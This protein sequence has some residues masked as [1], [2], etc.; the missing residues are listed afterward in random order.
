MTKKVLKVV[1]GV[2]GALVLVIVVYVI[3]VMASYYRL[4]DSISLETTAPEEGQVASAIEW[5]ADGQES[6][7]EFTIVS[8]NLGFGAYGPDFDFFM[9]GGS[10]SVAP[11]AQYVTDNV[12]GSADA[13]K[14]FDPDIVLFQEVD[15]DGTRSQGVDEYALL[16]NDFP[17]LCSVFVQNY[18]SPYLAWPLYAP[19]GKNKAGMATFSRYQIESTL[20]RSLPISESFSKFLDLDRCYSISRI[21]VSEEGSISDSAPNRESGSS[22]DRTSESN[23]DSGKELVIFNVHLS[24][25]GADAE[26]LK[27]Q[28]AMLFADMQREYEAGN[29][30]IAGGDFNHDMIGVSNEV[31]GNVTDTEASW[32]KPFDFASVPDGF[33]VAAKDEFDAGTFDSAATCRDAGRPYDG[34]NDRWVMDAFIYSDNITCIEQRTLD[35]DFAFSDHNPVY[36]RFSLGK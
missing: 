5:D 34:I 13:I 7:Q 9:D 6:A 20:R 2:L 3:Y 15:I 33:V 14:G 31:Y 19:H 17:T 30:V 28:R 16:R 27:G 4:D 24:A 29:Y 35:L 10:G 25:Y 26:V 22:Q 23:Q 1:G 11:S 32:A 12:N 8:A 18:D 21:P 36:L